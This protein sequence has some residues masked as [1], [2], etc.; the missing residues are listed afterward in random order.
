MVID[1][2]F[3]APYYAY[4]QAGSFASPIAVPAQPSNAG[5]LVCLPP[6]NKDW[7]PILLG[8]VH[9]LSNPSTWVA[10]SDADTVSALQ[11]AEDFRMLLA[12]AGP[13]CDVAMQL[14]PGCGLQYS[15]DGGTTWTDVAGWSANFQNCV[16]NQI[17]APVPPNPTHPVPVDEACDIAGYLAHEII[18]QAVAQGV[19]SFQTDAE[20]MTFAQDVM[21]SLAFAF[22]ITA[23]AML[24]LSQF[25]SFYNANTIGQF[26]AARDDPV[27][28]A[29]V[30]CAIYQAIKTLGYID[31]SNIGA[32]RSNICAI[33]YTPAVVIQAVCAFIDNL[34]LDNLRA[35]QMVGALGTTICTSCDSTAGMWCRQESWKGGQGGWQLSTHQGGGGKWVSGVGWEQTLGTDGN[36]H[37][38]ISRSFPATTIQRYQLG[39]IVGDYN[40][41]WI[42]TLTTYL[43][44]NVVRVHD[45]G[46]A[47]QDTT[48][49]NISVQDTCDM[50]VAEYGN[51]GNV[52]S[53]QLNQWYLCGP[54]RPNPFGLD[55][56]TC[57]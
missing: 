38:E 14:T 27:L 6:F 18:Q 48:V 57:Y 9:Q 3:D 44:G 25:Y 43:A 49:I 8:C 51:S 54:T 52:P 7:L 55:N 22:P 34:G 53:I 1:P 28:W 31:S 35:M 30:T 17:V 13:C 41:Q 29:D 11:Q 39:V 16:R 4:Q 15:T 32:V 20:L 5:T 33:S 10:S 37:L 12:Q 26:T 45:A 56:C 40:S 36:M 42:R 2:A 19:S 47:A 50:V 23:E 21:A 46:Y 24:A